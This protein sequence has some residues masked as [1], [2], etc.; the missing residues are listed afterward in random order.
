[1]T[2]RIK[3]YRCISIMSGKM[4]PDLS[5]RYIQDRRKRILSIVDKTTYS[6]HVASVYDLY[7][8]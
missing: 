3:Y 5:S 6:D 2:D 7:N 1:M 8:G 4:I